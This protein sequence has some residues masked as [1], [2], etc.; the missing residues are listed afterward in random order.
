MMKFAGGAAFGGLVAVIC[1]CLAAASA[2]EGIPGLIVG[3][4]MGGYI[5]TTYEPTLNQFR[6]AMRKAR[7]PEYAVSSS[8]FMQG[9][10]TTC[11]FL[12]KFAIP[13]FCGGDHRR[14]FRHVV[15]FAPIRRSSGGDSANVHVCGRC[16]FPIWESTPTVSS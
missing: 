12:V 6:A 4:V 11:T 10:K 8:A 7:V 5:A 2:R 3:V 15:D 13:F 14:G 16:I 1:Y 9:T